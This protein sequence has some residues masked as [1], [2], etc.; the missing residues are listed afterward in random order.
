M[1]FSKLSGRLCITLILLVGAA[2]HGLCLGA[3]YYMDDFVVRNAAFLE[4]DGTLQNN[5]FRSIP[6]ILAVA[7]DQV[8]PG[9]SVAQHV[10]N[11]LIHLCLSVTIF[12]GARV[13]IEASNLFQKRVQVRR[14]A[15]F[16]ALIFACHPICS[17]ALNYSRCTMIQ[18]VALFS[19]LAAIGTLKFCQRP[20]WGAGVGTLVVVLIAAF[21][22]D[23]G[24]LHAV[25]NV[26]I[27]VLVFAKWSA[28]TKFLRR[29]IDW[30]LASMSVA[31]LFGMVLHSFTNWWLVRAVSAF[32]GGAIGFGEHTLT[33]GRIFWAYVQR[34]FL[35]VNLSVDHHVPM[36]RSM[37]DVPAVLMTAAVFALVCVVAWMM[38][39][40]RL[41]IF[42][43]LGMLGLAPLLLR[44]LYPIS[45]LMVE[46]RVYPAMP[47]IAAL[48]GIGL[49]VCYQKNE[50]LMKVVM[51]ALVL[52]G[53]GGSIMRSA[54]WQDAGTLA[55]D[56]VDQYP[57]N[58]RARTE[59][60]RVAYESG[61]FGRVI[62][63]RKDVV[64]AV[65]LI[66]E[67]NA[68]TEDSGR[69]YLL[70]RTNKF[71]LFSE[72]KVAL[73]LAESVGSRQALV[74]IDD[75]EGRMRP[76]YPSYFDEESRDYNF[77]SPLAELRG[78]I[79]QH[80]AEQD[81]RI[82]AQLQQASVVDSNEP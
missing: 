47:W 55:Q 26:M 70:S 64:A 72:A 63:L 73:V 82:A 58:N 77:W 62:E 50:R 75:V 38:F 27:V 6:A 65:D 25:A 7:A 30:V 68:A 32:K 78:L 29:P 74:F 11:L 79:H 21:S 71:F 69:S 4:W 9:S 67:Y 1:D 53:V 12:W 3:D 23:P 60:Q 59:L 52:A 43:V 46:Y 45:E 48:A 44:F 81:R 28:V 18:L 2:A 14:A 20:S 35:P 76:H 56:V 8:F 17:E 61:D 24:I 57:T 16:G 40:K 5:I 54:V 80:G 19:V 51:L 36:T 13:F 66:G 42:G 15:F 10:W 31:A 49:A 37:A 33:Q 41:R 22:K 39:V 34:M